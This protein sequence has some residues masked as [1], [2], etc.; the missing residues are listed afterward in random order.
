MKNGSRLKKMIKYVIFS[1]TSV[2]GLVIFVYR[3]F[4]DRKNRSENEL[5][6]NESLG[7]C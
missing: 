4:R 3:K 5:E 2:T 7:L 6:K 1:L